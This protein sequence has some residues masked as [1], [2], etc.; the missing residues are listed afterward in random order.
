MIQVH[1]TKNDSHEWND[2]QNHIAETDEGFRAPTAKPQ[3]SFRKQEEK[4]EIEQDKLTAGN[5]THFI[6]DDFPCG[7]HG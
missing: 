2:Q 5:V 1:G 3:Q 4:E 7:S 6:L